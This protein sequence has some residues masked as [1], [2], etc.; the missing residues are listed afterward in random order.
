MLFVHKDVS[1]FD[2][3]LQEGETS[4]ARWATPYEVEKAC[5]DGT[6]ARPVARRWYQMRDKILAEIKKGEQK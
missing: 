5:E 6:M 1:L 3:A 2:L 4:D